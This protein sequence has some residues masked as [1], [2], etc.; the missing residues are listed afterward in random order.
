MEDDGRGEIEKVSGGVFEV[1]GLEIE[2]G[3][4]EIRAEE[5]EDGVGFNDDVLGFREFIAEAGHG[6]SKEALLST[7]PERTC[8]AGNEEA[9]GARLARAMAL[10]GDGVRVVGGDPVA[11]LAI[12]GA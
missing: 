9:R 3:E 12:R 10:L 5:L 7:H 4:I 11:S 6:F 8:S 1:G 2:N